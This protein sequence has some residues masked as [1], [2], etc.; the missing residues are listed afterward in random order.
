MMNHSGSFSEEKLENSDGVRRLFRSA[1]ELVRR[2]DSLVKHAA[3][4]EDLFAADPN[5]LRVKLRECCERLMF[6]DPVGHGKKA[7]DLLWRKVYYDVIVATKQF[8][9]TNS[10]IGGLSVLNHLSMGTGTYHHLLFRIQTEYSLEEG[11]ADFLFSK[12]A[13]PHNGKNS[14]FKIKVPED[15]KKLEWATNAFHRCL[16]CLGDLARYKQ[17]LLRRASH[18]LAERYY[19]QAAA[20]NPSLGMPHNQLGTLSGMSK[21]G[22]DAAYHYM[23]CLVS[24][25]SFEGS[26]ENLERVFERAQKLLSQCVFEPILSEGLAEVTVKEISV[27]RCLTRFLKFCEVCFMEE[28]LH[29]SV[30]LEQLCQQVLQDFYDCMQFPP[31][32]GSSTIVTENGKPSTGALEPPLW[33]EKRLVFRLVVM[34]LMCVHQLIAKGSSSQS[35][36][37]A[38]SLALFSHLLHYVVIQLQTSLGLH[39]NNFDVHSSFTDLGSAKPNGDSPAVEVTPSVQGSYKVRHKMRPHTQLMRR[40]RHKRSSSLSLEDSDLSEAGDHSDDCCSESDECIQASDISEGAEIGGD[41]SS[42]DDDT[43][44]LDGSSVNLLVS[45]SDSV[46]NGDSRHDKPRLTD[47]NCIGDSIS[48]TELKAK[49]RL[50]RNGVSGRHLHKGKSPRTDWSNVSPQRVLIAVEKEELLLAV[51]VCTD[52][53]CCHPNIFTACAQGSQLLWSRVATLLN[54]VQPVLSLEPKDGLKAEVLRCARSSL[55]DDS[56]SQQ[57][58]LPEDVSLHNFP[59]LKDVHAKLRFDRKHILWLT[60]TEQAVVRVACLHQFGLTL[61]RCSATNLVYDKRTHMFKKNLDHGASLGPSWPATD[62][63]HKHAVEVQRKHLME[64]MAHLWLQA[65]VTE[66]ESTVRSRSHQSHLSPYL[67]VTT[68]VLTDHLLAL[69]QLLATKRFIVVIPNA[70]IQHLDW[71]KK[72]SL[73]A[74]EA[75]RWLEAEF[76]RGNRYLRAQKQHEQISISPIKYPKRKDKEAWDYFQ[77]LECCNYLAQQGSMRETNASLV[78]LLVGGADKKHSSQM[79]LEHAPLNM[80]LLAES[81]GLKLE[82][83]EAF[84]Y[85]W[86]NSVKSHQR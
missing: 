49:Q 9:K 46:L 25:Q 47:S 30:Q 11:A 24:V 12:D 71:L 1:V 6:V 78:T 40:R 43:Q 32:S 62:Q 18:H 10:G 22:C 56:W 75:I 64:N 60:R 54:M 45:G 13:M 72:E 52:W 65:E 2:L 86:Q 5:L 61:T 82:L 80:A 29:S 38:F 28:K 58:P 74:R 79:T 48:Q 59:L 83:V 44:D 57:L 7:E 66:L 17:D 34:A 35:A 14:C 63:E 3:G 27:K 21:Y 4:V 41:G 39:T 42:S 76:H 8:W 70:V 73:Q 81:A 68:T 51:K 77:V 69:R 23:R 33:L 36:A 50:G 16:I 20:F 85:K 31:A 19:A 55:N 84:L 37:I 15:A 53:L 67:V 26:E